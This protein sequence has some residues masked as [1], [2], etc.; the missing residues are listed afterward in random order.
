VI[1]DGRE[2]FGGQPGWGNQEVEWYSGRTQNARVEGGKLIIQAMREEPSTISGRPYTSAKLVT[3]GKYSVV[4]NAAH[5]TVWIEARVKT[6][7]GRGLW[8][9]FWMLPATTQ[10][11]NACGD[12]GNWAASGSINIAGG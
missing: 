8:P 3:L 4:P 7:K 12:Y 5:P 6:P 2:Y 1:G 9:A 11:C 10:N